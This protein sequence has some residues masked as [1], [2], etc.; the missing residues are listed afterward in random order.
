MSVVHFTQET[1]TKTDRR[2]LP[3]ALNFKASTAQRKGYGVPGCKTRFHLRGHLESPPFRFQ[4]VSHSVYS[5]FYTSITETWSRPSYRRNTV[6][7]NRVTE[8]YGG[9][10]SLVSWHVGQTWA[11]RRTVWEPRPQFELRAFVCEVERLCSA[12]CDVLLA[13]MLSWAVDGSAG[14][15]A[16]LATRVRHCGSDCA[17]GLGPKWLVSDSRG[18]SFFP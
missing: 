16:S 17:E 15:T 5:E 2:A 9:N 14:S 13:Q 12:A 10:K 1:H 18:S 3:Q 4:R 8:H 6:L 7:L 11:G